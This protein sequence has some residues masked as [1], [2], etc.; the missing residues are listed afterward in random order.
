MNL[1]FL[2]LGSNIDPEKNIPLALDYLK[3]DP[4]ITLLKTSGTWRTKPIGSCC[5]DFLNS[6]ALI[7]TPLV[8]DVLKREILAQI[9]SRLGRVRTEDKNAPR[10]IDLDIVAVNNLVVDSDVAKFDHVLLPLAEIAPDLTLP[11]E[12]RT[13]ADAAAVRRKITSA[14]R[15]DD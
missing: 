9:E 5:N 10:T 8:P 7:Q 6:A 13:L 12:N 4:A 11:G 15:L 3:S 14:V 2:I 1:V